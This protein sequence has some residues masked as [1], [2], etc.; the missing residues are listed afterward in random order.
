MSPPRLLASAAETDDGL[1]CA[2]RVG[3]LAELRQRPLHLRQT[4]K[5][6]CRADEAQVRIGDQ[7]SLVV[8]HE[9]VTLVADTDRADHVPDE[10][11]VHVGDRHAR[12]LADM[13]ERD[14]HVGLGAAAEF[15]RAE[16]DL[17]GD[18]AHEARVVRKILAARD[19][20][21]LK[22]DLELLTALPVEIGEFRDGGSQSEQPHE[23]VALLLR[24]G[25]APLRARRPANLR[26]DVGQEFAD[27][28]CG[29]P[30]LLLLHLEGRAVRLIGV[31]PGV[32]RAIDDQHQSDEADERRGELGGQRR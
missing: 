24:L 9:G 23:I 11:Q 16:P 21:R 3:R 25:E 13:R 10:L 12:L 15:D 4:S 20:V 7:A 31:E 8:D 29:R 17:V 5:D 28:R 2:A 1:R 22:A 19:R 27:A 30:G 26:L 6:R 32:H 18:G 14:R